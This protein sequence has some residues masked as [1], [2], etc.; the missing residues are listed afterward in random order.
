MLLPKQ[1]P[2]SKLDGKHVLT[3]C[4]LLKKGVIMA[5]VYVYRV[6]RKYVPQ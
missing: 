5:Q 2:V 6:S 1:V 3:K 4:T